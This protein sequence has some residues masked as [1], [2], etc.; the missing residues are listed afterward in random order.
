MDLVI[1]ALTPA[2]M[3]GL[4]AGLLIV[5]SFFTSLLT[6]TAGIGGGLAMI[7]IMAYVVPVSALIPVHGLVQLGSNAGRIVVLRRHVAWLYLAAFI[8]G[9]IP[10][11][12]TGRMALGLLP[13]DSMKLVLGLFILALVWMPLP[14][15]AGIPAAGMIPIGF[16]TTG[17]SMLFGATGPLNAV[18]LSK[19]FADRMRLAGTFA[20]VMTVQHLLKVIVFGAAGFAFGPWLPLIAAMIATGL[21]GTYVGSN[22]L[23]KMPEARFRLIFNLLLSA[24]ALDLVRQGLSG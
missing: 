23:Q 9:A 24:L 10:G 12:I 1:D 15:L 17:L 16:V 19:A 20:A 18:V 22:L 13:G 8:A 2:G 21:A 14:K 3:S 11:A 5:A 6:V 7:A 4:G